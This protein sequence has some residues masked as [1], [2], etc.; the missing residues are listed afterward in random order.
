VACAEALADVV[1]EVEALRLI[2]AKRN[3]AGFRWSLLIGHAEEREA[4]SVFGS[5]AST[6]FQT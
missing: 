2:G 5:A 1:A 3:P 6:C 4:A